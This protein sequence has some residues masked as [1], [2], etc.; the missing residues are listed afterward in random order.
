MLSRLEKISTQLRIKILKIIFIV[1]KGHIGGSFSCL[2]ILVCLYA[3]NITNKCQ[4][5]R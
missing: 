1:K 2:D 4:G 3:S 5:A